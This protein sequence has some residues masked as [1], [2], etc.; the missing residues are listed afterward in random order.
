MNHHH[1]YPLNGI[2]YMIELNSTKIGGGIWEEKSN[3]VPKV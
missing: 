2:I 3:L 1:Y